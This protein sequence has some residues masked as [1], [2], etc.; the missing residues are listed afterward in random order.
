MNKH[1]RGHLETCARNS[2][3]WSNFLFSLEGLVKAPSPGTYFPEKV[4][5]QR[6]RH[7]PKYSLGFRTRY[8]RQDQNPAP[9]KYYLP[10]VIGSRQPNKTSSSAFSITGRSQLG[11]Y[12]E[13]LTKAPG[14]GCYKSILPDVY[15]HKSPLYSILGRHEIASDEQNK[16]GPGQHKPELVT[17]NRRSAPKYSLGVRHSEFLCP[18]IVD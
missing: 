4:H 2:P 10:P 17:I 18:L 5:P 1:N 8:H 6:E 13:D 11:C 12:Y 14:P 3:N 15:K 7:A 16:P 9:N